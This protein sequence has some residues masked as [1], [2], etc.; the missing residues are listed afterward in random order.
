MVR[1]S[2]FGVP[3]SISPSLWLLLAVLGWCFSSPSAP[4]LQSILLF[5]VAGFLCLMVHEMGHALVGRWLGGGS[6]KIFMTWLGG[7]YCN[8][9]ATLTRT[10]GIIMSAAGPLFT[11]LLIFLP[12]PYFLLT[13]LNIGQAMLSIGNFIVGRIPGELLQTH[14][15]MPVLFAFY[16]AEV[17]F[18]W[19]LVNFLPVFPLDGGLIMYGLTR[20]PRLMHRVSVAVALV[21]GFFFLALNSW[22]LVLLLLSLAIFNYRCLQRA[23]E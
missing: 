7:D 5:A 10:Q 15:A 8:E 17:A 1:F 4:L 21:F 3:V 22:L 20:S 14:P 12:L 11:F 16:L 2:L 19:A 13:G 9:N 6:P 18:W 23:T